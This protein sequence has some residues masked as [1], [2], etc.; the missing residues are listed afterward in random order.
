MKIIGYKNMKTKIYLL[1]FF[2]LLILAAGLI[3]SQQKKVASVTNSIRTNVQ[4]INMISLAKKIVANDSSEKKSFIARYFKMGGPFMWPLLLLSV[5]GLG[6]VLER[7]WFFSRRKLNIAGFSKEVVQ[8]FKEKGPKAALKHCH[9]RNSNVSCILESGL[10]M[11]DEGVERVEKTIATNGG[12]EVSLL[13]RG[14]SI[15]AAVANL[16]PLLGFLGTVTGM[17]GAFQSIASADTVS[18]K[19][20]SVG[21]FEALVTTAVGLIVAIPAF[22]FHNVFVHKIDKFATEVEQASSSIVTVM[23]LNKKKQAAGGE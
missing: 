6:I 14:L 12:I 13:E 10:M 8:V 15:L 3:F 18:A 7:F 9:Q 22:A 16:A 19:L 21:I 1:L 4:Q 23:L 11:H 2:F 17:I 20:V 5:V